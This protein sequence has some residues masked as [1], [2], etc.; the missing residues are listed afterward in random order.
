MK[1]DLGP[2]ALSEKLCDRIEALAERLLPAGSCAAGKRAWRAGSVGG[3]AGT[4][5]RLWLAGPKRGQWSCWKS[6]K[7]GD[8]LDLVAAV[9]C[10]GDLKRACDWARDWLGIEQLDP[11]EAARLKQRADRAREARRREAERQALK[12]VENASAVWRAGKTLR[13]GDP[14]WLYLTGR[15]CALDELP[16][17]PEV[18]ELMP[19]RSI[20]ALWNPESRRSWPALIAAL[21]APDGRLANVHRIWLEARRDAEGRMIVT[22]APLARPKLSMPGGYAGAAVRLWRGASAK[23][24]AQMPEGETLLAGEGIEDVLTIV[25]ERPEWRACAVLS[26]GGLLALAAP[27]ALPPQVR[28]IVWIAQNDGVDGRGQVDRRHPARAGLAEGLR[29]HRAQGRQTA[30]IRPPRWVKDVNEL[31]QIE[32]EAA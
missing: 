2:R 6:G 26:S 11:A 16:G 27:G 15:G 28:R 31:A 1:G 18:L 32:G 7:W 21:S 3:E 25:P 17:L 30:V 12:D 14:G 8:A 24:W 9:E 22:K 23:P 4:G 19:L 10:G 29:A 20:P 13:P 5:M